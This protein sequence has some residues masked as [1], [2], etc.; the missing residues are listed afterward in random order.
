MWKISKIPFIRNFRPMVMA[1]RGNSSMIP[2]NTFLAFRDAVDIGVDCIETDAHLTRDNEFVFFHDSKLNRTTNGHGKISRKTLKQLKA[3]DAG[4]YFK[5]ENGEFSFRGK[6]L[7]IQSLEDVMGAFP[8]IKFNIDIKSK[9]PKAP[10][11]LARKLDEIDAI[12]R[13]MVGS[14]W[15]KQIKRFREVSTAPTSASVWETL[16]FRRKAFKFI[17]NHE[18]HSFQGIGQKS[19]FKTNLPYF[20]LQIPEQIAHIK[21]IKEKAF[22]DFAHAMGIAVHVWTVNDK[23]SMERLINWGVDGV[24]TDFPLDLISILKEKGFMN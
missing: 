14:F 10:A 15:Q 20:A 23:A 9:N 24:F 1:H 12:N 2:E 22:M 3:L 7:K 18:H 17:K 8:T 21:I 13:V 6:G 5:N 16:S 4:Y 11:L 19:I